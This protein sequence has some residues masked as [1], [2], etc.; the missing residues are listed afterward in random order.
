MSIKKYFALLQTLD[1]YIRRKATGNPNQFAQKIGVSR[2]SILRILSDFK[3]L[4]IP[5]KFSK[6]RN[7]YYYT[8]DGHIKKEL[9]ERHKEL[10]KDE[11][12]KIK[13][14]NSLPFLN[15]CSDSEVSKYGTLYN[16]LCFGQTG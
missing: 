5:I 14:G 6:D 12:K 8:E 10:S 1:F 15:I 7:S 2:R 9:F 16:E 3:S 13:G 4:G 11:L